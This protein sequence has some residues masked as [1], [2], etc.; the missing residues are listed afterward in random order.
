MW[1]ETHGGRGGRMRER[2]REGFRFW[3]ILVFSGIGTVGSC[4]GGRR[5]RR[6]AGSVVG[7]N[8]DGAG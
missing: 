1:G 5:G 4:E 3:V 7:S 6:E 2:S 8:E